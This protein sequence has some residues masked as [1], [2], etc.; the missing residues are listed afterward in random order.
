M[1][2]PMRRVTGQR[3]TRVAGKSFATLDNLS[4]ENSP[5]QPQFLPQL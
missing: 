4:G 5:C 3:Q 1:A 2:E